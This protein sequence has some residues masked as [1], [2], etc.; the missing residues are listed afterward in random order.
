MPVEGWRRP[1]WAEVDL[2][3]LARNTATLALAVAPSALCAVVKA[4]GYGHG[5]RTIA[6]TLLGAGATSLGVALVDEGVEL[7]ADG[8]DVPILLL[9]EVPATALRDAIEAR[10]TLTVGSLRGARDVCDAAAAGHRPESVHVKVDTGM[11]R[12]G[13]DPSS[14]DVVLGLLDEAAV[15]VGGLWTHFPVADGATE[16]SL[17]F[18]TGQLDRLLAVADKVR[19]RLAPGA[20]LH[21][22]N[23]AGALA[24]PAARLDLVR[25]GL[26]LFGYLPNPTLGTVLETAGLPPLVPVLSLKARVIA[27][28]DLGAGARP[29]YGRRRALPADARVATVPIGYADGVPRGLFDAGQEVLLRGRRRPLA[30]VV[31]MDQL[32]VDCGD[33]PVEVGDE[34]VLLGNQSNETITADEWARSLSTISWEVLCGIKQRVPKLAVA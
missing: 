2:T 4:D 13:V 5:S 18:T 26:G 6:K 31:T 29:S 8:I 23:T 20:V 9:S 33:D 22:A 12:Q 21:A 7:R 27:V 32:V 17:E 10:L 15:P 25:V 11:H 30:G 19:P 28:R 16:E 14:L 1:A 24:L 3:M 34:V